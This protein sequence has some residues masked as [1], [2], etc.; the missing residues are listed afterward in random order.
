[1][2]FNRAGSWELSPVAP[3]LLD[4]AIR[5]AKIA[6]SYLKGRNMDSPAIEGLPF[7]SLRSSLRIGVQAT[8]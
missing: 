5:R 1:V 4:E 3:F 8:F 6:G 7:Q 2:H